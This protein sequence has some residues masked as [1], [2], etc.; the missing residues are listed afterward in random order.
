M[1]LDREAWLP[2]G[3]NRDE[4]AGDSDREEERSESSSSLHIIIIIIMTRVCGSSSTD[5]E[6][7]PGWMGVGHSK[8]A[9]TLS[10]PAY[11]HPATLAYGLR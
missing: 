10:V 7:R 5:T 4:S 2:R 11:T 1:Q 6:Q 3:G 9:A 8:L